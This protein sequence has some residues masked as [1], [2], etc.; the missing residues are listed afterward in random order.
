[1]GVYKTIGEKADKV[2]RDIQ[3]GE[4]L[5]SMECLF[6]RF[7]YA[8]QD[9]EG[10]KIVPHA[11]KSAFL[12]QH[13]RAYAGDGKCNGYRVGRVLRNLVFCGC[14][15]VDNPANSHSEII[16]MGTG[17]GSSLEFQK[18]LREVIARH[19]AEGLAEVPHGE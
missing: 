18:A 9:A 10:V 4:K 14:A 1:M 12:T 7:D 5:V 17:T 6:D 8:V 19:E 11:M 16:T 13:L 2:I 3:D 15:I